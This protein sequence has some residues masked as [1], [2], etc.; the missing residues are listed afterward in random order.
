VAVGLSKVRVEFDEM[1]WRELA[2]SGDHREELEEA[3][4]QRVVRPARARAP[5]RTGFGAAT[6]RSEAVLDADG[7][8]VRVSWSTAAAYMRFQQFGT[9]HMD[10]NPFL[11]PTEGPNV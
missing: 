1:G 3:A 4:D 11:V 6:I 9:R 10:A 5:K 2:R 8:E 7:W